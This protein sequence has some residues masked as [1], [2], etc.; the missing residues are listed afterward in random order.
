METEFHGGDPLCIGGGTEDFTLVVFE[1][2]D[3]VRD[4]ARMMRNVGRD[5]EFMSLSS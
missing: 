1:R 5:A 2:L 4:V 3:P